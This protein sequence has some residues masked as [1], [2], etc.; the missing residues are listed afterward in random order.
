MEQLVERALND[1]AT[2]LGTVRSNTAK[3]P[4]LASRRWY[5]DGIVGMTGDAATSPAHH[6]RNR[7]D[8][9]EA[10]GVPTDRQRAEMG[11]LIEACLES[12]GPLGL[13]E[14]IAQ[15]ENWQWHPPS[16]WIVELLLDTLSNEDVEPDVFR[17]VASIAWDV[18]RK[19][20]VGPALEHLTIRQ[21]YTLLRRSVCRIAGD[22][23]AF[24]N[25]AA[26]ALSRRGCGHCLLT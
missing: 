1:V 3:V 10:N 13:V 16:D 15:R 22:A 4:R 11:E 2:Q 25:W 9:W 20:W 24:T 5:D 14:T 26:V 8:L 12:L 17:L 6:I 21:T 7:I 18:N 23:T 19:Q